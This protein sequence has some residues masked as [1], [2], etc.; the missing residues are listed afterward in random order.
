K[1]ITTAQLIA[2]GCCGLRPPNRVGTLRK[3]GH[4][5][6]TIREGGG[7][8]RYRLIF[9][10]PNPSNEPARPKPSK[11]KRLTDD[12]DWFAREH[13]P[14]PSSGTHSALPLFGGRR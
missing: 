13:G 1:G 8:F 4:L 14:R 6:E 9:E 12:S 2:E 5:I 10:N 3:R 11:Q 7:V